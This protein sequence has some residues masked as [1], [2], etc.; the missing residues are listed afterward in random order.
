MKGL[1]KAAHTARVPKDVSAA[2]PRAR[3][4]WGTQLSSSLGHK[5]PQC[6]H[7][8]G[9][10]IKNTEM[11]YYPSASPL[12]GIKDSSSTLTGLAVG[13]G[14]DLVDDGAPF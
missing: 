12:R 8:Q 4:G 5:P 9:E 2:G 7:P 10:L 6:F 11:V 1:L 13:F 3:R 14:I